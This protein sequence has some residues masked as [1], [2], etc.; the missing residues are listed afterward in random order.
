MATEM[1]QL[2]HTSASKQSVR[3]ELFLIAAPTNVIVFSMTRSLL[4]VFIVMIGIFATTSARNYQCWMCDNVSDGGKCEKENLNKGNDTVVNCEAQWCSVTSYVRRT[5]TGC[6][7]SCSLLVF[8]VAYIE[9]VKKGQVLK[10]LY[11]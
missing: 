6:K 3:E 11:R 7:C 1:T 10:S 4:F 8:R 5:G 2:V 9:W